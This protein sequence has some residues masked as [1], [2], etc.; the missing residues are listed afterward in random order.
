MFVEGS[1]GGGE[2]RMRRL[3]LGAVLGVKY[4]SS[5][6]ETGICEVDLCEDY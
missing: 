3:E 4:K 5:A 1:D 2:Y 6:V